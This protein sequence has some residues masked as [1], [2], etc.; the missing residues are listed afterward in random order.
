M[1][2]IE[3]SERPKDTKTIEYSD[4]LEDDKGA[5]GICSTS[6]PTAKVDS[7]YQISAPN[8]SVSG[9]KTTVCHMPTLESGKSSSAH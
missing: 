7:P 1:D 3:D 4:N 5:L 2:G 6:S 9:Q 8:T